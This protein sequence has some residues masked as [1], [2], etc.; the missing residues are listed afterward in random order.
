M[1]EA[2]RMVGRALRGV[3]Q[4]LGERPTAARAAHGVMVA[5]SV[6]LATVLA[7]AL[8]LEFVWWAA[9][10]AF[11][12]T[13]ATG[14]ATVQRVALRLVGTAAGAAIAFAMARWLPFDLVA[15]TLFLGGSAL[16]GVVGMLASPHGMAWLFGAITANMVL[17][18]A[19]EDPR[20]VPFD[21][22]YRVAEVAVG[23]VAALLIVFVARP[24]EAGARAAPAP[25]WHGLFG[26]QWP[27]LLHGVRAAV[28]VV[29]VLHAWLF[30]ALPSASQM[31]I[32]VMAVMVAPGVADAAV[33]GRRA[34]AERALH[35]IL[36][37]LLGGAAALAC[38][39]LSVESFPLWLAMIGAGVWLC[40][41]VQNS[42]RGIGYVGTQA[43]VVFIVT[44]IQGAGPPESILPGLERFAGIAA[45]MGVLLLVSLVVWPG[46]EPRPRA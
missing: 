33:D 42:A 40:I 39:A 43:G 10:T 15:L 36:G 16:V 31:A 3:W 37:C 14:T 2:G 13:M 24:D 7:L 18:M 8:R 12:T 9:I 38:L 26:L 32:T 41:H 25:G 35:R 20:A 4:E 46:P 22:F 6:P 19:L 21:A 44:F 11:M 30:L 34:V 17:L 29:M 5:A 23:S 45:G 1:G 27:L 28:A